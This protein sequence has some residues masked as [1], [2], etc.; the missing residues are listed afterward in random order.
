[1]PAISFRTQAP[2]QVVAADLTNATN[3]VNAISELATG[4]DTVG[5]IDSVT[6]E[7]RRIREGAVL[8]DLIIDVPP[9]PNPGI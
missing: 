1:M 7:L 2:Q 6:L 5:A 9:N 3:I 8:T 4:A